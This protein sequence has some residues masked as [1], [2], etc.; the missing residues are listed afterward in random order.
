MI[1]EVKNLTMKFGQFIA[2]DDLSFDVEEGEIFGIAGPNGAG[3]TTLFNCI[4]GVY[5]GAGE[6]IFNNK[7]INGL[8]PDKVCRSGIARTFQIPRIFTSMTIQENLWVGANFG[9]S[10]T[11]E[12]LRSTI[13]ENV[14]DQLGLSD[15]RNYIGENLSLYDRKLAMLGAALSTK[16]KIILLDEPVGGLSVEEI[17]DFIRILKKLNENKGL[18][19]IIIEHLMRVLTGISDRLMILEN[20]RKMTIG[21][22]LEVCKDE[23]IIEI[24]LGK[25][26]VVC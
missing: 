16:P 13:I 22:P 9:S 7:K 12:K 14:L 10:L 3:K 18:T 20:G 6:I 11:T 17:D 4:S 25:G 2:C 26:K 5:H 8:T 21:N 24:Y 15:K 1:L 23:K 19:I